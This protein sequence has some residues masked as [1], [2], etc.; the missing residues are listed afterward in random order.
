MFY[1]TIELT[2]SCGKTGSRWQ[3]Y[4]R[5]SVKQFFGKNAMNFVITYEPMKYKDESS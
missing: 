1:T 4:A 2:R 5:D 3:T